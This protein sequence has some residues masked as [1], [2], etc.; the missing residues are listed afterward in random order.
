MNDVTCPYCEKEV[1][2]NHDD[3]YGYEEGERHEQHCRHCDKTFVYET[4]ISIDHEAF[5]ADCL[6][7][8]EHKFEMTHHY[9]KEHRR[10]RCVDCGF[11]RKMTEEES[12][13]NSH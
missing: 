5:K 12:L 2:I 11:E 4:S 9:P 6:N 8:G 13:A 10:M 7:D 3:G 1:E